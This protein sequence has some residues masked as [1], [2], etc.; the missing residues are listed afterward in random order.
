MSAISMFKSSRNIDLLRPVN[1]G[2][3][4]YIPGEVFHNMKTSDI[5]DIIAESSVAQRLMEFDNVTEKD[6]TDT[7]LYPI[8]WTDGTL[9]AYLYVY[10]RNDIKFKAYRP[11]FDLFNALYSIE[12]EFKRRNNSDKMLRAMY[13]NYENYRKHV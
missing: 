5:P 8:S 4:Y 10:Y 1:F 7:I 13:M 6:I 11:T 12:G 2:F 9:G 3:V